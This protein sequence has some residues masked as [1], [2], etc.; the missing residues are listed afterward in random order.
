[1]HAKAAARPNRVLAL[2]SVRCE[3]IDA[4][5]TSSSSTKDSRA[6]VNFDTDRRAMQ[7]VALMEALKGIIV[8]SAGFGLL[9]LVHGDVAHIAVSLV[10]RLHIDPS[11]YY[12][13]ILLHGANQL[14]DARLWLGAALAALYS[15]RASPK[16]TDCGSSA[17]GAYGSVL[18]AAAST[19][20]SRSTSC[21]A[22][23]VR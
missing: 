20:P 22:S 7:A 6:Q 16:A 1:M 17:T 9:A 12:A 8:F 13:G 21:G 5:I 10:T 15:A 4:S 2:N 3:I 11:G 19:C 23:R 14:T 18:P